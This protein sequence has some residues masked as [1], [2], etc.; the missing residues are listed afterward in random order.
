MALMRTGRTVAAAAA[1]LAATA[2]AVVPT[3]AEA[4]ILPT[5]LERV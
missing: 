4:A 5:S 3:P 1:I 2:Y